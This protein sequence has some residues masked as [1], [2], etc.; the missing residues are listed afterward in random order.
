MRTITHNKLIR[1]K[2]PDI[3]KETGK[4]PIIE[5]LSDEE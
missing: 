3:I 2:I 5:V 4:Q 1:D